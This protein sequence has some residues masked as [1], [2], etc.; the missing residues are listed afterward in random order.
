MPKPGAPAGL[1][2]CPI[3]VFNTFCFAQK[4]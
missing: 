1:F 2:I 3:A 4:I